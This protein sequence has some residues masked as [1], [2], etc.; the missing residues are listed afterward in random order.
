LAKLF[1]SN[2]DLLFE[3]AVLTSQDRYE[4]FQLINGYLKGRS[5]R[6]ETDTFYGKQE[7]LNL[8]FKE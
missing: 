5:Q 3:G 4:I 1:F 7:E 8:D 6:S 2:Q